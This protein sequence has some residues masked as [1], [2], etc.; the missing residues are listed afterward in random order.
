[1]KYFITFLFLVFTA[2]SGY[3][4]ERYSE[5]YF[6]DKLSKHADPMTI[7]KKLA[8]YYSDKTLKKDHEKSY[9]DLIYS[10][11]E[12]SEEYNIIKAGEYL[13]P[14]FANGYKKSTSN[15]SQHCKLSER[16]L[17]GLN[18]EVKNKYLEIYFLSTVYMMFTYMNSEC[19]IDKTILSLKTS[20]ILYSYNKEI[21]LQIIPNG[22]K[23]KNLLKVQFLNN[24]IMNLHDGNK[25]LVC[26]SKNNKALYEDIFENYKWFVK[27][28]S[29]SGSV[30]TKN[31][32]EDYVQE[33]KKGA[34]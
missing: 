5:E 24:L 33:Q 14:L 17:Y 32:C 25:G 29:Y 28:S 4:A 20:E 7:N 8:R 21:L 26:K 9:R 34:N 6:M 13:F 22:K 12:R 18:S 15:F 30:L 10:V 19:D 23:D 3:T 27:E 16:I 1:M 2:Q 11:P 31:I